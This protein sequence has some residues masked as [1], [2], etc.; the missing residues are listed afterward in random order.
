MKDNWLNLND[1]PNDDFNPEDHGIEMDEIAKMYAIADMKESKR[2]WA[3]SQ[4]ELFYKDFEN[5]SV[6][7]AVKTIISLVRK[8]EL[9]KENVN[10]MLNNMILVFQEIEEYEKCHVC[11][12]IKNG[13]NAGI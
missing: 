9:S 10:T 7:N 5:L 12:Q 3:I 11:L 13:V 2:A 6:P 4:A 1:D 8:N